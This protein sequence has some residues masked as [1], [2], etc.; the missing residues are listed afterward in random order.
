MTGGRHC[1]ACKGPAIPKRWVMCRACW[2]RVPIALRQHVTS[3]WERM[4][5][6]N[7]N[8]MIKLVQMHRKACRQAIEA[9]RRAA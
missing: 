1:P 7:G 6:G 8:P 5:K 3:C 4:H 2:R 9:A